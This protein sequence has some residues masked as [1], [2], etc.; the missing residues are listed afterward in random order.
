MRELPSEAEHAGYQ[1]VLRAGLAR[2]TQAGSFAL[3]PLGMG[4][5]RR[6]EAIMH[7]ELAW[8]DGQE[9]RTPLVQAAAA[10]EQSGRYADYG[11]LMLKLRDRA[12]RPLIVAPTH[13]EAVTELARRE[14]VSYRQLP[15]IV[16]Q[17]HTKYRDEARARGGLMRMCEFTMLDAYSFDAAYAGLDTSYAALAGAFERIFARCG[18]RFVAV[19]ASADEMGGSAPRE[20]MA[21]SESGEDTLVLCANC[22]YAANLEVAVS[23]A[24]APIDYVPTDLPLCAEIATP[25]A[26]T[27]AELAAFLGL[28]TAATA[29]AV[30]FDTPERGLV[31]A[32]I[33]SDL[34]VNELKLRAVAGVSALAPA[35]AAQI[36]AVGA[37]PG[38]A[39]AVGLHVAVGDDRRPT[40][41]D[42]QAAL[43]RSK[44]AAAGGQSSGVFVIADRSVVQAGPLVAGANRAGFHLQNVVYGRDWQATHV[45]EIATVRAG[46]GCVNCGAALQLAHGVEIG[47]I[48]KLGTRFSEALGAQFLAADGS[49]QPI[50]MG[51]YGIGLERMLQIIVEQH[52]DERGI[53]WPASVAPLNVQLVRLGKSDAVRT[54]SDDVYAALQS[55]GLRVLYG[56]REESPGVKFNDADLIGLPLRVLVSERLLANGQVEIKPR[57]G[58][59]ATVARAALLAEVAARLR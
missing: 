51:S 45:A 7:E 28:P 50:V 43:V 26:S 44:S 8:I 56:D 34:E 15:Q 14:V 11:P 13:E 17:V 24:S 36:T 4:V 9:F 48:F 55:A 23:A 1:L 10:W 3:L 25:H 42:R 16:Y 31:F 18:V 57:D 30:F 29:K 41:D 12:D 32:V 53:V 37:V 40:T 22:G 46:D 19:E 2:Q 38:Y 52:H 35:S 39:S 6:I 49:Q 27:I 59:A 58:E 5:L 20:Y 33:R 47:H 21:L 54:A